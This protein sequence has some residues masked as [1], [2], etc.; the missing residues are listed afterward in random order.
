[1]KDWDKLT[2]EELAALTDEQVEIYKKLLYAQNGIRFP[3]EPKEPNTI[4]IPKDKTVYRINL[5][6][7]DILFGDF[8]EAVHVSNF[9]KNCKSVCHF[10]YT[11]TWQNRYIVE[12]TPKDYNNNNIEFTVEAEEAYSKKKFLEVQEN[13]NTITKLNEQYSEDKSEYDETV[14]KAIEVTQDFLDKLDEARNTIARRKTLTFKYYND[15]LP[16]AENN[17]DIA[18]SFLEKAYCL[19]DDDKAFILSH[20]I[21]DAIK[22]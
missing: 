14:R 9:L 20:K 18:M 4:N 19:N 16:L 7:F 21:E 10:E 22:F 3:V 12:G 15:Y 8:Q 2:I 13:L 5:I 1:M 17:G 6:G 11:N